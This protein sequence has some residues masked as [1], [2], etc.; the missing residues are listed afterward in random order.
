MFQKR[1][2]KYNIPLYFS[3]PQAFC[4]EKF[5]PYVDIR[6]LHTFILDD[7]FEDPVGLIIPE[8]SPERSVPEEEVVP[9]GLTKEDMIDKKQGKTEEQIEKESKRLQA[10]SNAVILEMIGDIPDADVKPPENVLF[11]CQLN[12]VT[13]DEDLKSIFFRFGVRSCEVFIHS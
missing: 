8:K 12:P 9:L 3:K 13:E 1:S 4:N 7:P 5:R 2:T 11:V 6:I 10:Q